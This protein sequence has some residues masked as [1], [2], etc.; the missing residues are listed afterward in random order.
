[1]HRTSHLSD[2]LY[3]HMFFIALCVDQFLPRDAMRCAVLVIVILSVRLSVRL[4]HT[5]TR[6]LCPHG[7]TYDHDFFTMWPII[8]ASGLE[9][10]RLSQKRSLA[11]ILVVDSM[12]LFS[13]KFSW[14]ALKV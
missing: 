3:C 7:S 12:G 1:M 10:S 5:H 2:D 9:I 14:F 4:T 6:G 11:Y 13:F 8:L